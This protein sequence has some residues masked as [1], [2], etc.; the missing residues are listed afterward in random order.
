MEQLPHYSVLVLAR[1]TGRYLVT[2]VFSQIAKICIWYIRSH[3][4]LI[5]LYDA[6]CFVYN[7]AVLLLQLFHT[8]VF[9]C[10]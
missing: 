6:L 4:S 7:C 10:V 1:Y 3:N 8:D 2:S 9:A 5:I